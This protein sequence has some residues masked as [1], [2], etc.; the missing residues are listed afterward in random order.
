[1]ALIMTVNPGFGGQKF[2]EATYQKIRD[3]R[4]LSRELNPELLIQ[5]DGGISMDNIKQL[6]EAGVDVF[7]AGTF[8][9]KSENPTHTINLLKNIA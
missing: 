4:A 6:H 8:V 9:F 7:V 3:L 1:M 2:I 5:V